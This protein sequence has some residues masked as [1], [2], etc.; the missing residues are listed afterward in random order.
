MRDHRGSV[1]LCD[2]LYPTVNG[3][4]VIAGTYTTWLAH[5]GERHIDFRDGI[6]A[7]LRFQVDRAGTYACELLLVNRSQASNQPAIS[8]HPFSAT[9]SDP[10][11]P[12]ELGCILPPFRVRCPDDIDPKPGTGV[13]VPLL[14]WFKIG[15][16]DVASCPLNVI[17]QA[18]QGHGH[19]TDTP[20]QPDAGGGA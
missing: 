8:R 19:A 4:W 15:G 10:L 5:P 6:H 1:I 3:K 2:N 17:F 20:G 14:V 7:Y 16:E 12:V 11:S 18:S 13:G 9:I